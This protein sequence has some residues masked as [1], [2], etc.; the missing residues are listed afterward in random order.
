MHV[1]VYSMKTKFAF[2]KCTLL[3]DLKYDFYFFPKGI[4]TYA[5]K[6]QCLLP[7][8]F[9]TKGKI[10][11]RLLSSVFLSRRRGVAIDEP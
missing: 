6:L 9:F 11:S 7:R 3:L 8:A 1:Y 10:S 5:S 2:R 4:F